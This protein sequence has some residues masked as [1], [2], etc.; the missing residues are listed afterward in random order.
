MRE[1]GGGHNDTH[2]ANTSGRRNYKHRGP[3]AGDAQNVEN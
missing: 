3:E 1:E 2:R